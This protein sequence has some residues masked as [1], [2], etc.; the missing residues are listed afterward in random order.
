M[1]GKVRPILQLTNTNKYV[2]TIF[3]P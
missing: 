2:N 3:I 1:K